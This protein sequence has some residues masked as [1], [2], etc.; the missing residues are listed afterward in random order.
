MSTALDMAISTHTHSIFSWEFNTDGRTM[1]RVGAKSWMDSG[2]LPP[3]YLG[4]DT[5]TQLLLLTRIKIDLVRIVFTKWRLS[6]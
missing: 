5:E 3:R 2:C 4:G 6:E 1:A